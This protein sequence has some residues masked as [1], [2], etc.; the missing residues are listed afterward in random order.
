M[1]GG[2]HQQKKVTVLKWA[3]VE[4]EEE[5]EAGE[6]HLNVLNLERLDSST[7]ECYYEATHKL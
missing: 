6:G 2:D 1:E 4:E 7:S 5:K 3:R